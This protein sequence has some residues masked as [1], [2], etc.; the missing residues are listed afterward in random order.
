VRV[1][2]APNI[3]RVLDLFFVAT[4]RIEAGELISR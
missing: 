2:S 4:R 3:A 1:G